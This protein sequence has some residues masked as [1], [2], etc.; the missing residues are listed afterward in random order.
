MEKATDGKG[1]KEWKR[2]K[3]GEGEGMGW[4][5]IWGASLHY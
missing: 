5:G 4:N 1:M 3:E 2:K